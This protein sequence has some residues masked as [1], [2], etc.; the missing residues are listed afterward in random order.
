MAGLFLG[1]SAVAR[2]TILL[3]LP[4]LVLWLLRPARDASSVGS[5]DLPSPARLRSAAILLPARLRAA[6]ILLTATALP[7]APA[8]LHNLWI[9]H[10]PVLI[11]SNGGINFYLGNNPDYDGA[12]GIRPGLPWNTLIQEPELHGIRSAKGASDYW[13]ARAWDFIL[14]QPLQALELELKKTWLLLQAYEIPRNVDYNFFVAHYAPWLRGLVQFGALL[15]LAMLGMWRTRH[16]PDQGLWRA[17]LLCTSASIIAFFVVGRYRMSLVPVLAVY[18]AVGLEALWTQACAAAWRS[19]G[20][21]MTATAGIALLIQADPFHVARI[22]EAEGF[23]LVGK[24]S[25]NAGR[26]S[27]SIQ[28]FKQALAVNPALTDAQFNLARELQ[29]EHRCDE[30]IP[31]YE[32]VR[33]AYPRDRETLNNLAVCY[34]Q[35]GRIDAGIALLEQMRS[36]YPD[37]VA[38]YYN[39]GEAYLKAGRTADAKATID[40]ALKLAPGADF[41]KAARRDVDRQLERRAPAGSGALSADVTA[42][43]RAETP[44][45]MAGPGAPPVVV[46]TASDTAGSGTPRPP[47][48]DRAGNATSSSVPEPVRAL[49]NEAHR[50]LAARDIPGAT[51]RLLEV[52][53]QAPAWPVAWSNLGQAYYLAGRYDEARKAFE[54]AIQLNPRYW[55]ARLGLAL[56]LA[57]GFHDVPGARQALTVVVEQA[58]EAEAGQARQ[59]LEG[60]VSIAGP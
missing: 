5:A 27:Q 51:A 22:D 14:G 49:N 12:V 11:S 18:G 37:V 45:T 36:F 33:A 52:I 50:L 24:A 58:P 48:S 59:M 31:H 4:V 54:T 43:G 20:P 60:L 16:E 41:L 35:N 26:R 38:I 47:G 44:G 32:I 40:A 10:E 34:L 39:L 21:A 1:L 46:G 9:G 23:N 7:I 6:A 8:S 29:L 13:S 55:K 28:A 15:P 3:M 57:N 19:L 2:P 25:S 42:S 30:A 56:T 53:R 17:F